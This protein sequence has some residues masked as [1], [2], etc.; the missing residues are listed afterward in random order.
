MRVKILIK[1]PT[2]IYLNSVK[3]KLLSSIKLL[4]ADGK[5]YYE[6]KFTKPVNFAKFNIP[7]LG[8]YVLFTDNDC[9]VQRGVLKK[10]D[11]I[12]DLPDPEKDLKKTLGKYQFILNNKIG[13]TPAC[14]S[15]DRKKIYYNDRFLNLP[16]YA[17]KFIFW[18]ELGHR[19]YF[20]ELYCDLY[21]TKKMLEA[22]YN[23]SSCV[24]S[25][26]DILKR[27]PQDCE[28]IGGILGA[29]TN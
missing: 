1:N 21:A 8:A 14:I 16:I 13:S 20:T 7:D 28:R 4:K 15:T 12:I 6:R 24:N 25:L 3:G 5:I 23:E 19:F 9:I 2:T 22:G 29:L 27:S 18:H 10:S 17:Q 26:K 11:K